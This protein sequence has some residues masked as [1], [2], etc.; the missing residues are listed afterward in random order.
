MGRTDRVYPK[1]KINYF[2]TMNEL[3]DE[4][5]K[6]LI[7]AVENV[8]SAMLQG[9]RMS[10]RGKASMLLG[11]NTMMKKVL[12]QRQESGNDRDK[13]LYQRLVSEKLIQGN[14]GLIF[15]NANL[16]DIKAVLDANKIQAPARQGSVAPVDVLIPAGNTGL[17]PTKT[18]FFQA[19]NIQ[20]K[21][22]K[23]TVEIM[24]DVQI[25]KQGDKVGSSEA[26]LLQMLNIKPFF[27]GVAIQDVYDNGSV[28]GAWVLDIKDEDMEAKVGSAIANVA[29]VSLGLGIPTKASF[30]HLV[31]NAF[32]NLLSISVG[33]DY[34]FNE[35][36]G[37][38]LKQ[39]ILAGPAAPSASSAPAAAA[40]GAA[41][42]EEKKE[43]EEEEE[44]D[45]GFGLF[46]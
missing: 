2:K 35:F 24:K 38:T 33:T 42:K 10:L 6:I 5:D 20:T 26:T 30:P 17:E 1:K 44:G 39:S 29:A 31:L 15:T 27:Y 19:L 16:G 40:G 9:I 7:V 3:L 14:V 8:T 22:T 45:M 11:K 34:E 32:K 21:I 4:N 37:N 46:G 25:I 18:S 23:G 36:N 13:M 12:S 41:A 43:E 28:Y